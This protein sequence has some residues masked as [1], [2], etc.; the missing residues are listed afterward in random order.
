ML[1]MLRI[2]GP[3]TATTLAPRLG[4][5]PARRRTTCASSPSTASSSTTLER[6]NGRDRGGRPRT[7]RPRPRVPDKPEDQEAMDAYMQAIAVIYTQQLQTAV[8]EAPLLPREWRD[9]STLSDYH[10]RV[11]A[12]TPGRSPTRCTGSS[13]SCTRTR[14]TT[15]TRSTSS[16]SSRRSRGRASSEGEE[17]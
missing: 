16:S 12:R 9:A 13:W 4:S 2:D 6:G 7:S 17:A 14:T 11:T 10:V 1:G 5:T 8:E 3:A 15:R